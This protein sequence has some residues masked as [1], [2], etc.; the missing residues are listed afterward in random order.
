MNQATQQKTVIKYEDV[1]AKLIDDP[2]K[3]YL[4]VSNKN[5]RAYDQFLDTL[6]KAVLGE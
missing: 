3:E 6:L 5:P 2:L 4:E 1:L